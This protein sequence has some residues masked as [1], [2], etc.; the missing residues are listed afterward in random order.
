[1]FWIKTNEMKYQRRSI[2][3]AI[4]HHTGSSNQSSK[5]TKGIKKQTNRKEEGKTLIFANDMICRYFYTGN[6]MWCSKEKGHTNPAAKVS[7]CAQLGCR[8]Q[9]SEDHSDSVW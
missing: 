6:F 1:M 2:F 3:A 5:E 9:D 7:E 8:I 4:Q